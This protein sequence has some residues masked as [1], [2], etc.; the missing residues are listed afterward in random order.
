MSTTFSTIGPLSQSTISKVPTYNTATP[1]P[2]EQPTASTPVY[3]QTGKKKKS[4]WLGKLILTVAIV[5][6]ALAA[7]RKFVPWLQQ[8][9]A[10]LGENAK[11][12]EKAQ[13]YL[14]KS[15][16]FII[17]KSVSVFGWAKSQ[18]GKFAEWL[19]GLN[20]AS[21]GSGTTVA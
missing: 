19:K 6:G 7:G 1:V 3:Y 4:R 18:Y 9:P 13:H 8:A 10:T 11:L 20:T 17:D 21:T 14:G 5:A 15:G 2:A 12:V 16:Q